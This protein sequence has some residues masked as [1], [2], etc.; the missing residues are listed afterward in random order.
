MSTKKARLSTT[1]LSVSILVTLVLASIGLGTIQASTGHSPGVARSGTQQTI[2]INLSLTNQT[3]EINLTLPGGFSGV[4][5][6]DTPLQHGNNQSWD[7]STPSPDTIRYNGSTSV[8]KIALW[9]TATTP[10]TDGNYTINITTDGDEELNETLVVDG[11]PPEVPVAT[12]NKTAYT[13]LSE[14]IMFV[15]NATDQNG[16]YSVEGDFSE[17]GGSASQVFSLGPN[18]NWTYSHTIDLSTTGICDGS[19]LVNLTV[20]DNASNKNTTVRIPINVS[21]AP[22]LDTS[23]T[24]IDPNP[25]AFYSTGSALKNDG[26]N[27]LTLRVQLLDNCDDG[28]KSVVVDAS[29]INGSNVSM[30]LEESTYYPSHNYWYKYNATGIR[31]GPGATN[32]THTIY[33]VVED[34]NGNKRSIPFQVQ[35]D[36][37][38]PPEI[39]LNLANGTRTTNK[40]IHLVA[41]PNE[42]VQEC[43]YSLDNGANNTMTQNGDAWEADVALPPYDFSNR[44]YNEHNVTVYC[45]DLV[46]LESSTLVRFYVYRDLAI[47]NVTVN[48]TLATRNQTVEVNITIKTINYALSGDNISVMVDC[49]GVQK[50]VNATDVTIT[51][52]ENITLTTTCNFSTAGAKTITATITGYNPP[53]HTINDYQGGNN[54]NTTMIVITDVVASPGSLDYG[55]IAPGANKTLEYNLSNLASENVTVSPPGLVLYKKRTESTTIPSGG[56]KYWFVTVGTNETNLGFARDCNGMDM[57]VYAPGGNT[58]E[59]VTSKTFPNPSRGVWLVEIYNPGDTDGECGFTETHALDPS[60]WL[61]TNHTGEV[62]VTPTEPAWFNATVTVPE[63]AVTGPGAYEGSIIY[64][65]EGVY[66]S[67]GVTFTVDRPTLVAYKQGDPTSLFQSTSD[68]TI[69]WSLNTN[70]TPSLGIT[71]ANPGGTQSLDATLEIGDF[72]C[73]GTCTSQRINA[74]I[75]QTSVTV[76]PDS[77]QDVTITLEGFEGAEGVYETILNV[78]SNNGAPYENLTIKLRLEITRSLDITVSL[79]SDAYSPG[80]NMTATVTVKY[81]DGNPVTGLAKEDFSV[82]D[83]GREGTPSILGFAEEGNGVYTIVLPAPSNTGTPGRGGHHTLSVTASYNNTTESVVYTGTGSDTYNLIEPRLAVRF[84]SVEDSMTVGE[85]DTVRVYI[86]NNGLED[87]NLTSLEIDLTKLSSDGKTELGFSACGISSGYTLENGSELE[88]Q[89]EVKAEDDGNGFIKVNVTGKALDRTY[90]I[91]ENIKIEITSAQQ[92]EDTSQTSDQQSWGSYGLCE[93]DSD[94]DEDEYCSNYQCKPLDCSSGY[95]ARDH[96]C[97]RIEYEISASISSGEK[98]ARNTTGKLVVV[99]KNEGNMPLYDLSVSLESEEW[100]DWYEMEIPPKD[101]LEPGDD[102]LVFYTITIPATAT[103]GEH[104]VDVVVKTAAKTLRDT[105]E[106][107]VE[108]DNKTKREINE[109]MPVLNQTLESL[110]SVIQELENAT[111]YQDDLE[112][113]KSAYKELEKAIENGDYVTA[114]QKKKEIEDSLAILKAKLEREGIEAGNLTASVSDKNDTNPLIVVVLVLVVVAGGVSWLLWTGYRPDL[115]DFPGEIS[116]MWRKKR[117]YRARARTSILPELK[118]RLK[119]ARVSTISTPSEIGKKHTSHKKKKHE[120]KKEEKET[121]EKEDKDKKKEEKTEKKEPKKKEPRVI[122]YQEKY[123]CPYCNQR[124][125][126]AMALELHKKYAHKH[127]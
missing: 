93:Y 23:P 99:I 111:E 14:T 46:G 107:I 31:A 85:T 116:R 54:Q 62:N 121:E 27:N 61:K 75:T 86:E 51:T 88:C 1:V 127:G 43:K 33:I 37:V 57:W 50:Y 67:V 28:I 95:I 18:G 2:N 15:V 117:L 123:I 81:A 80:D 20:E 92:Q 77:S 10:S 34:N 122:S 9:F 115:S 98:I 69:S 7:C 55:S 96:E 6:T 73:K 66:T 22:D 108:P 3:K 47:A 35:V 82:S 94:C 56:S 16:I 89:F 104:D 36:D 60:A 91:D 40:T 39:S 120:E 102:T 29:E 90:S 17:L 32:G 83:T 26:T 19:Y 44:S 114:Y 113:I 5:C 87:I 13:E 65:G 68:N 72:S 110:E 38:I 41:M 4:S 126:S 8:T 64:S 30:V 79:D 45:K 101:T 118:S 21:I 125:D 11:T 70:R 78:T 25:Q 97:V 71:I 84:E 106:I 74:S 112:D 58:V 24:S 42:D 59:V 124:F 48:E 109:T 12:T 63:G 52:E 105:I 119:G 49:G 53:W 76:S 100:S 103:I